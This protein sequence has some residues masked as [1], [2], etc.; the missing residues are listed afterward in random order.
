MAAKIIFDCYGKLFYL[1]S[2]NFLKIWEKK[3]KFFLY[4]EM[5]QFKTLF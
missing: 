1:K 2:W 5:D 4:E 3:L